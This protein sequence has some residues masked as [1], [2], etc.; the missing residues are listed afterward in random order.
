MSWDLDTE[1]ALGYVMVAAMLFVVGEFMR[2]KDRRVP[3]EAAPL[4]RYLVLFIASLCAL[5]GVIGLMA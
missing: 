1:S 5:R 2:R 4:L 3:D